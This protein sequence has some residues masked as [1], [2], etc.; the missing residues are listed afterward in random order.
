MNKGTLALAG[1]LVLIGT[2][3][4]SA[5]TI[6]VNSTNDNLTAANGQCTLRKALHNANT[7]SDTTGGDCAAG[8]GGS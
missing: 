6:T 8:T 7:N 2:S 4:V 5:A 3:L 1:A